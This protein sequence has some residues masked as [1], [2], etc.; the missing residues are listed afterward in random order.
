MTTIFKVE[1]D[2]IHCKSIGEKHINNNEFTNLILD[3]IISLTKAIN[4]INDCYLNLFVYFDV[5]S[6]CEIRD[7]KEIQSLKTIIIE[8]GLFVTQSSILFAQLNKNSIVS[9]GCKTALSD[10]RTNIRTLREYLEDIENIF[11]LEDEPEINDIINEL[12]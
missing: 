4:N 9:N 6:T 11:L 2:I 5:L 7:E 3:K 10:L 8:S 1:K 12:I